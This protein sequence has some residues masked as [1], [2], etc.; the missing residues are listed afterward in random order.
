MFEQ[1][2]KLR[3]KS[4]R[5]IILWIVG[6]YS[7]F[8]FV[9]QWTIFPKYYRMTARHFAS[10]NFVLEVESRGWVDHLVIG[11]SSGLHGIMPRKITE[12]SFSV[13]LSGASA[14]DTYFVLRRLQNLQIERSI[15]LTNSMMSRNHY[16]I[17]FWERFVMLGTYGFQELREIY[18][19]GEKNNIFPF[20]EY[21]LPHFILKYLQNKLFMNHHFYL[22]LLDA[23]RA[24][25][26][27]WN[28]RDNFAEELEMHHGFIHYP[29]SRQLNELEF[30]SPYAKILNGPLAIS[31]TDDFFI[32]KTIELAKEKGV[33]IDFF[34][35]PQGP[36]PQKPEIL[37]FQD[38]HRNYFLALE[39][40]YENFHFHQLKTQLKREHFFDFIHL[41]EIGALIIADEIK[42]IAERPR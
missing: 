8:Y 2:T 40:E 3:A 15:L 12:N 37:K 35:L 33:P 16:E 19:L 13:A 1:Q 36:L 18:S 41:N 38:F 29:S 42:Q 17:D 9:L 14:M 27:S 20:N 24:I 6:I 28:F 32:R 34:E 4:W 21:S 31:A 26:R 10:M 11:D 23:P 39:K 30:V 5:P 22:A 25:V 7:V